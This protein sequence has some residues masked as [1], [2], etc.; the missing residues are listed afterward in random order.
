MTS[1]SSDRPLSDPKD[2]LFGHAPFAKH[3]AEAIYRQQGDDGIVLALYGPWG[4]GKSTV[5]GFVL[6]YLE[7]VPERERPVPVSFNPWWFSGQENLAKALLGQLEAVLP[8][9]YA[10]FK[11]LG[12]KLSEFSGALGGVAELAGLAF[13][14]KIPGSVVQAGLGRLA[15]QSKDVPALKKVLSDLLRK[16]SKRVLVVIDDIDRLTPAEVRQLFTVIK[17]L[18]DFPYVTY[19][20][21]FDREAASNAISEETGL[22]GERYLEKIIQ[23]PFELPMVDRAALQSA[24]LG[25]L[26]TAMKSTPAGRFDNAYWTNIYYSG[27]VKLIRVP[28]DIVRL[29]NSLSVTYPAVVG[30][31]NPV[32][33]IAIESMRVFLPDVYKAIR[34]N[35]E[36]FTGHRA[37]SGGAEKQAAVAF[38]D[39]WLKAVPGDL[40]SCVRDMLERIF[41]KL[42]SVWSNMHYSAEHSVQWR[43]DLRV[44]SPDVFQVYFRFS[45]PPGALS[46]AELDRFLAI[47]SDANAIGAALMHAAQTKR[48]DGLSRARVLLERLLDHV[49]KDIPHEHIAPVVNALLNVGDDLLQETDSPPGSFDFG[50][51][52]RVTRVIYHLLKRIEQPQRATLLIGALDAG[53]SLRCAQFLIASLSDESDKAAAG[54]GNA[55]LTVEDVQQLKARWVEKVQLAA[56]NDDLVQHRK[57]ASLLSGWR[58]W[59]NA[60]APRIWWR[61]IA[62]T[63]KGLMTLISAFK[64]ETSS[65]TVGDFAVR[66]QIRVNPKSVQNYSDVHEMATRLQQ[67]LTTNQIADDQRAVAEQFV[68]ECKMLADGK[69]PDGPFAFDE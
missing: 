10:G 34:A 22:P 20:L 6:H 44:C 36:Q 46:R 16:E 11:E 15:P 42:E 27:I 61:Q 25:S 52:S 51:E 67:L 58:H 63:D 13:G 39:E 60:D 65:N 50:N 41:P 68:L 54:G 45:L 40:V 28:R 57:L 7:Q 12:K 35:E 1:L 66:M 55:L 3:L 8:N 33:F 2:D 29:I 31:V 23:V 53:H 59:G 62:E 64:Q 17:A 56:V 48:A 32:D 43:R 14:V 47:T 37:P 21:A 26:D 24:F 18:A 38:H 5:L 9:K 19:L 69:N 4:S 30:E 49:E